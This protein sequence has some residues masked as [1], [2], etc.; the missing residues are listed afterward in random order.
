MGGMPEEFLDGGSDSSGSS[1]S[2]HSG[3]GSREQSGSSG[4]ALRDPMEMMRLMQA[5]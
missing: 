3:S 5:S 2:L 4:G 1:E